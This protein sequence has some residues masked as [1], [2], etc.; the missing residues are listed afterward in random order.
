R[1]IDLLSLM[2]MLW[3]AKKRILA[4]VL[5][6]A[7]VGLLLSFLL[8]Q[9][10]TSNAIVTPA[11]STQWSQ[12]HQRLAALQV[13]G[14]NIGLDRNEVFNLFLKKFSSQQEL[15][16]Y[17]TSSPTLMAHFKDTNVDTME[18]HRAIVAM[19]EK[20]KAVNDNA[21]KKDDS[22]P[23]SSWTLSFTGP[24]PQEAQSILN[25]YIE[26][27]AAKVVTQSLESIRD[28]VALKVQTEKDALELERAKLANI[29]DTRIKRLN[30]S[31]Q[32][33]KAAGITRPVYSNG[34]A[35]KDDPDFSISL[36]ADGIERKLEIEKSITDVSELNAGLRN[37]EYQLSLLEKVS[38]KDMTFPVFKYQLS[39]SLPVKKDGP[40]KGIII[41][42][43]ALLGGIFACGS[44][45]LGQAMA[46]RRPVLAAVN[47][48][49]M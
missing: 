8:P 25:N 48:E 15:E 3:C 28:T 13:L 14:V 37:S 11:E 34:Q 47:P 29:Q 43:A 45:L 17:I 9:K 22:Q 33:A 31:L 21:M 18:L 46:A 32:V 38:V 19:S 12:L 20:M 30:Y 16:E 41:V 35:V 6:F 42:L 5:A 23:Y 2:D 26:F 36:G 49:S 27:V 39:A 7:L 4:Y 44:V 24:N 10:W 1:E 40:G